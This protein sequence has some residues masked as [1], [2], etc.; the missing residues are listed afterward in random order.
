MCPK[1][2]TPVIAKIPKTGAGTSFSPCQKCHKNIMLN[3][4]GGAIKNMK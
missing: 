2:G 1:C 4:A 3:Y